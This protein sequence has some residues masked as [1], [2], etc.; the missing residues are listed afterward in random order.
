MDIKHFKLLSLV[1]SVG[2]M[3]ACGSDSDSDTP[4]AIE[5]YGT[6]QVTEVETETCEA[7]GETVPDNDIDEYPLIITQVDADI[8]ALDDEG[9]TFEGKVSGFTVTWGFSLSESYSDGTLEESYS[10]KVTYDEATGDFTGTASFEETGPASQN[11]YNQQPYVCSGT[12][13]VTVTCP[14][15][16]DC[17]VT[18]L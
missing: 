8:T 18:L 17:G 5:I 7:G 16:N 9:D 1:L 2:V 3:G 10:G 12:S 6:W 15:S 11:D 13:E 14:E 4:P